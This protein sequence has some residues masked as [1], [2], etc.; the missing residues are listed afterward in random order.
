MYVGVLEFKNQ[1]LKNYWLNPLRK[2]STFEILAATLFYISI[3]TVDSRVVTV[4]PESSFMYKDSGSLVK[5]NIFNA[6]LLRE[7]KKSYLFDSEG[8]R[9]RTV[10]RCSCR[11]GWSHSDNWHTFSLWNMGLLLRSRGKIWR[12]AHPVRLLLRLPWSPGRSCALVHSHEAIT[13]E[14]RQ[15]LLMVSICWNLWHRN[16]FW[17]RGKR[18]CWGCRKWRSRTN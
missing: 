3:C 7:K 5:T 12:W 13:A 8:W 15:A 14:P 2:D 10:I 9:P 17:C 1:I 4:L 11:R 16:G 6:S 18:G